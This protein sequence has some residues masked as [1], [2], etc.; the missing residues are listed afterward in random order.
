M[1]NTF[2]GEHLPP[3]MGRTTVP[4]PIIGKGAIEVGTDELVVRGV[5]RAGAAGLIFLMVL[6][7]LGVIVAAAIA[8]SSLGWSSKSVGKLSV[9]IGAVAGFGGL[10]L[11]RKRQAA[12]SSEPMEVRVPWKQVKKALHE[13][14]RAGVVLIHVKRSI[15]NTE[16]VH[17]KPAEG[18][19]GLVAALTERVGK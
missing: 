11:I 12:K 6:G 15:M 8:F 1:A 9:A 16:S 3:D 2:D 17:F 4:M 5:K 18:S 10:T 19:H 7:V 14:D 13:P